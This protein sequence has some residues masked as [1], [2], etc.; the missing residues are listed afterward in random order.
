MT[1]KTRKK[2]LKDWTFQN[3]SDDFW[4]LKIGTREK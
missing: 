3:L 2:L 4:N 1:F